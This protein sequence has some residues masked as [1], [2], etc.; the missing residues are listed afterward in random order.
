MR[1]IRKINLFLLIYF[2]L[3]SLFIVSSNVKVFA[4]DK[5][6]DNGKATYRVEE[7]IEEHELGY[8]IH[9]QREKAF[10]SVRSGH[11]SGAA[12]GSG[13]GGSLLAEK[14]YQQQVN[15][16]D[17]DADSSAQLVPYAGITNG[18]WNTLTVR[19]AA[20][21]FEL[22]NP[23]KMVIAAVN[24]DWFEISRE[25]KA[26]V[27][28]TISNGEYYK[29]ATG[30]PNIHTLIFNNSGTGKKITELTDARTKPVLTIY[31]ANGNE[32]ISID[33]NKVN[34]EPGDKEISL[35][36][37]NLKPENNYSQK[38][39]A[40]SV[41]G[42][43]VVT[44]ASASIT[45][46]TDS[47]YG[48]GAISQN[49]GSYDLTKGK[50]AIKTNNSEID[51]L[52]KD[53]VI[54][55]CQY[56]YVNEAYKDVTNAI[57]YPYAV[58]KN[59][60][61]V[62]PVDATTTNNDAK[63]RKPRTII[64]QRPDGSIILA[65]VDGRQPESNMFGMSSMEMGA[66]VEYY[67]CTEA[68]KLDGGGSSTMIIRKQSGLN[69]TASFNDNNSTEWHVVNSPSDKS[70][71][72][73]GNCLLVVV[74]VPEVTVEVSEITTEYVVLNV[75]LLTQIEKYSELYVLNNGKQ[76]KVVNG[77]VKVDLKKGVEY[78]LM[79]YGKEGDNLNNLGASINVK[80]ANAVPTE[81]SMNLSLIKKDDKTLIEVYFKYD[82]KNAMKKI[83]FEVNNDK[84][85]TY[86]GKLYI[87][88]SE[89]FFNALKGLDVNMTVLASEFIGE[90]VLVFEDVNLVLSLDF[91][92]NEML[93]TSNNLMKDMFLP[94][95]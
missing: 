14:E 53:G 31:D 45:A 27:G 55:R 83:E 93:F 51:S 70:E 82:N 68:W 36:Y 79:V 6:V 89:E 17:I 59:G 28:V 64:G 58:M 42:G 57:C 80:A 78:K 12:A 8:G 65:S 60:E 50:F 71:R 22:K 54:I 26:S 33:I 37:P 66:L 4:S 32:I 95:E 20:A 62:Y 21:E 5:I 43:W 72:S 94:E 81:L 63:Y 90:Q 52:L 39:E 13:G 16:L 46:V 92:L 74:D 75:A 11:F 35:Y 47:F 2:V 44:N 49:N 56:E 9:Y 40:I 86:N 38:Y 15:L 1:K 30:Y 29:T 41:S 18:T 67:G 87:E 24:G 19:K 77:K 88:A 76:Y 61:P 84:L 85:A 3:F 73:D 25:V 7:T 10:S 23:G 48:K 34:Q 91:L 69:I